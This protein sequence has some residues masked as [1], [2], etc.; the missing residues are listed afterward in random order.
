MQYCPHVETDDVQSI[1]SVDTRGSLFM[2]L[3]GLYLCYSKKGKVIS[4]KLAIS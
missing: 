1:V 4:D 3:S 2:S